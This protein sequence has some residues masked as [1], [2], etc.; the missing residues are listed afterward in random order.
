[1]PVNPETGEWIDPPR[2]ECGIKQRYVRVI[3]WMWVAHMVT[4][5][6]V[7]GI[8]VSHGEPGP[9]SLGIA[10][11]VFTLMWGFNGTLLSLDFK[12]DIRLRGKPGALP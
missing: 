1:M 12:R 10:L 4:A 6:V 11:L 3:G 9:E 7:A 2:E 5:L 8:G